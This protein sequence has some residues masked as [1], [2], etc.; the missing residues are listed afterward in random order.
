MSSYLVALQLYLKM[1]TYT[2]EILMLY[3]IYKICNVILNHHI[4]Q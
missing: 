4:A 3:G 2:T 1:N